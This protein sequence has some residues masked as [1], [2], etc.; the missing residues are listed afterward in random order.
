MQLPASLAQISMDKDWRHDT[1]YPPLGFS[2]FF[3]GALGNG[4]TFGLYWPIGREAFEPIVVHPGNHIATVLWRPAVESLAM[5]AHAGGA[6][7]GT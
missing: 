4:D 7:W 3:E 6:G 1:P 2:P 5:A